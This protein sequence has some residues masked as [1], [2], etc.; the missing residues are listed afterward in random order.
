MRAGDSSDFRVHIVS[1]NRKAITLWNK[2]SDFAQERLIGR[3]V[4]CARIGLVPGIDLFLNCVALCQKIP[5][6]W[7]QIMN[8]CRKA[9]PEMFLIYTRS[10]QGLFIH[11]LVE[12]VG[13]SQSMGVCTGGHY[14]LH[15]MGSCSN[16]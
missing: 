8:Q 10:G 5:V 15:A 2:I 12:F 13:N 16:V 4:R 7:S 9:L 14:C 3:H 6:C 11:E 1:A